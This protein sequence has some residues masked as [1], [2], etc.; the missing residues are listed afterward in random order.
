MQFWRASLIFRRSDVYTLTYNPIWGPL[1][2]ELWLSYYFACL[3]S[4]ADH[5]ADGCMYA[6][7]KPIIVTADGYV[8]E[9][10]IRIT[11]KRYFSYLYGGHLETCHTYIFY[12]IIIGFLDPEN[13]R[14]YTKIVFLTGLQVK[15]SPKTDCCVAILFLPSKKIP[16][17]CQ[18]GIRLI[19]TQ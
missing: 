19:P 6:S 8:T 10:R 13:I 5:P 15:T 2:C 7:S 18:A 17:G 14:I 3:S 16:Q 9:C 11:A 4:Q 1:H 12:F